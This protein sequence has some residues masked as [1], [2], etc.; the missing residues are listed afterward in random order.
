M[1]RWWKG[2][3]SARWVN[4]DQVRLVEVRASGIDPSKWA[5]FASMA[6]DFAMVELAGLYA[7]E[8]DAKTA[9]SRLT[10]GFDTS[11]LV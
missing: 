1:N 8:A 6:D 5:L 11:Q 9:A 10:Q 2:A 4:T 3:G 7:T